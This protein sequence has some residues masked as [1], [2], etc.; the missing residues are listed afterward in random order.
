MTIMPQIISRKFSIVIPCEQLLLVEKADSCKICSESG[1]KRITSKRVALFVGV[2]AVIAIVISAP[3][4]ANEQR[5]AAE[6]AQQQ[7]AMANQVAAQKAAQDAAIARA[8][9][10]QDEAAKQAKIAQ[11]EA[12]KQ[13]KAAQ[14]AAAKHAEFV[15][16][17]VNPGFSRK[18]GSETVAIAVVSENGK[19]NRALADAI[20]SRFK[21]APVEFV[22]SLFKPAFVTNGFFQAV[23]NG[24]GDPFDK[25]DLTKSLNGVVLAQQD[26]KYAQNAALENIISATMQLKV[27]IMPVSGQGDGKTWTFTAYG[28]GFTKE[29]AR[30]A[31]EERLIKQITTDTNMTL[32]A[33]T[34]NH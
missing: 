8:Q 17:Y 14:E 24:S 22:S 4:I 18:A 5:R 30:Q 28:P 6:A 34:A 3:H 33:I 26:V 27:A 20:A 2:M 23:F 25:L 1:M 12:A 7:L 19:L 21:T 11:D 13:A 29:V 9:A 32:D 10:A 16:Q 31:A 15:A